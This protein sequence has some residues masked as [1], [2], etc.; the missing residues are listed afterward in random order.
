MIKNTA[1]DMDKITKPVNIQ[2][3]KK[4]AKTYGVLPTTIVSPDLA[5][6]QQLKAIQVD[7]NTI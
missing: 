3:F 2:E 1:L 5:A 4:I 6:L 7:M